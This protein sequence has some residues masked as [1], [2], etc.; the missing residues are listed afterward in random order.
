MAAANAKRPAI[1]HVIAISRHS[2]GASHAGAGAMSPALSR[3]RSTCAWTTTPGAFRASLSQSRRATGVA[4]AILEAE[5][6]AQQHGFAAERGFELLGV[7]RGLPRENVGQRY[8]AKRAAGRVVD[9]AALNR[10][11]FPSRR[12]I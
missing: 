8:I 12:A 2:A 10:L 5:D 9:E 3:L 11:S 4:S 7:A 1:H 6:A